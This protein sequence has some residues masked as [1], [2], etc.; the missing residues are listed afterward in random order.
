MKHAVVDKRV[1]GIIRWLERLRQSYSSGEIESALMEAECARADL[2]DLRLTVW[3]KV[4]P[5]NIRVRRIFPSVMAVVR[6]AVLAAV[7]V[8]MA[9]VP[10]AR[11]VS[12]S[13]VEE[14]AEVRSVMLSESV[15]IAAAIPA[16]ESLPE[17]VSPAGGAKKSSR[18]TPAKRVQ[19]SS[20]A[21]TQKIRDTA[22]ASSKGVP[23]DKV[24]GMNNYYEAKRCKS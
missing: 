20:P 18:K 19:A 6:P 16:H 4:K 22:H 1:A 7:I 13:A 21:V 5:G 14:V 8:M 10:V 11:D 3:G 17:A 15:T 2:E 23:Y 9:V 12:V 24:K